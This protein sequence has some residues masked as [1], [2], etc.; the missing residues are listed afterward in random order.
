M[1]GK[2]IH[3]TAK[4]EKPEDAELSGNDGI[5][6][7]QGNLNAGEEPRKEERRHEY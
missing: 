3:T 2:G 1:K 6:R 7:Y 4:S 5:I